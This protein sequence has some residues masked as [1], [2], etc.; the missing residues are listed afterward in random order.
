M[1]IFETIRTDHALCRE[2]MEQMEESS[3]RGKTRERLLTKLADEFT[4]HQEAEEAV[5]YPTVLDEKETR[6]AALEA[7]EEHHV[8]A[9]ILQDLEGTA[10]DDE[11][12]LPKLVVFREIFE[13]HA[14]EEEEEIFDEVQDLLTEDEADDMGKEFAQAKEKE[15]PKKAA[16]KRGAAVEA[17]EEEEEEE[18]EEDID[19]GPEEE[20][21]YEEEDEDDDDLPDVEE[22]DE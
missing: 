4:M 11:R 22:E 13:H 17:D 1:D 15:T 3:P 5:F 7:I 6:D 2:I 10:T 19:E 14:E 21:E 18:E 8:L 9:M 16:T 20:E 12:W